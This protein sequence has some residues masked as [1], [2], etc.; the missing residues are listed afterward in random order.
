MSGE[1]RAVV[2]WERDTSWLRVEKECYIYRRENGI[3]VGRYR[4]FVNY[5]RREIRCYPDKVLCKGWRFPGVCT[6]FFEDCKGI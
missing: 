3:L 2:T 6:V 1:E 5:K 4:G